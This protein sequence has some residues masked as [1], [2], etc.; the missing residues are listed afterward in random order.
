MSMNYIIILLC[1]FGVL[2][3]KSGTKVKPLILKF[4][5]V[6]KEMSSYNERIKKEREQRRN[7]KQMICKGMYP[8]TFWDSR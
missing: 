3:G 8:A 5:I 7:F 2:V 1:T 4:Q 6:Q